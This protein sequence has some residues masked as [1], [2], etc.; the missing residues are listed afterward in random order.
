MMDPEPQCVWRGILI[1]V[2][3]GFLMWCAVITFI[4]LWWHHAA[5]AL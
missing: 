4:F 1:G 5:S 3:I 2:L